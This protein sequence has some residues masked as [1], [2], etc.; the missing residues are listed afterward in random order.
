MADKKLIKQLLREKTI[1]SGI[2]TQQEVSNFLSKYFPEEAKEDKLFGDNWGLFSADPSKPVKRILLCTT[3]T[4]AVIQ[5]F[6]TGGYDLLI[7]H[8][9]NL[10]NLPEVPQIIY[11]STMDESVHGHNVYFMR[12]MGLT[13]VKQY[14][15]VLLKGDLYKPLT[16]EEFKQYLS[17]HGFE[18]EGLVWESPNADDKI[19]SVL[20]CSG[21][22]GL[23]M[24]PNH[25]VDASKVKADV[26]VTG[27]LY[28]H[29]DR[30]PNQFKYLIELG[31][32]VSEKPLFK[33]MKNILKNRWETLEI[34][35]AGKEI[36]KF[37]ADTYK[38]RWN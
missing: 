20:Y 14:H 8:H 7:S 6:I 9:D 16:L 33:W 28:T 36:D 29:P 12:K 37:G 11:H 17:K 38:S 2:P 24:G 18:I 32:T 26:Y 25:I 3:A 1:R 5:S 4:R 10:Y 13:N 30:T 35:L 22:G 27:E 23:L 15:Q 21:G 31:H 34:D 19:Q